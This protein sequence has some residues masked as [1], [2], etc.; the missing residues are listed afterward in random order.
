MKLGDNLTLDVTY[1]YTGSDRVKVDWSK[2]G[3]VLVR[4]FAKGGNK[5]TNDRYFL[6]GKASLVL[7]N[8]EPNDNGTFKF[9]LSAKDVFKVPETKS[10]IVIVP[11][12]YFV[13]I[14]AYMQ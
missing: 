12:K 13:R 8:I 6:K 11:G 5:S 10:L 9:S 1:N 3:H 14:H 7:T 4:K 2:G